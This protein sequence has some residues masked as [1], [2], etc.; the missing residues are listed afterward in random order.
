M[1][2][3]GRFRDFVISFWNTSA[4]EENEQKS[5]DFYLHKVFE[6]SFTEFIEGMKQEAKERNLSAETIEATVNESM[7]ILRNFNPEKG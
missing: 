3:A 7:N 5:W 2:Q 1:I 4:K 6:G